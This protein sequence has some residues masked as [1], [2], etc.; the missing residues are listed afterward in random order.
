MHPFTP[1][2]GDR[3]LL[4][5]DGLTNHVS[6]DELRIGP[7][8][9][10]DPQEWIDHLVQ[11]ALDHGS[12]D[13]VT[14]I[15]IAFEEVRH[16]SIPGVR[17]LGLLRREPH[18]N[19]QF[20][21]ESAG[22][23]RSLF[24]TVVVSTPVLLTVVATFILGR[25]SAEMTQAQYQRAV[26]GQKQSKVADEWAFFQA[27]R[28]RGTSY[29]ATAVLLAAQ[30]AD[31][32]TADTLVDA[33]DGLIREIQATEKEV[34]KSPELEALGKKARAQLE[35]ING[36]LHPSPQ[37]PK[38]TEEKI[39]RASMPSTNILRQKSNRSTIAPS[40]PT[41]G[42]GSARSSMTSENSSPNRKSLRRRSTSSRKPSSKPSSWRR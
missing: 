35:K 28:I 31:P 26:A 6:E 3:L 42:P 11:T 2:P 38:L 5:T 21:A 22:E 32:F 25:S 1:L 14:G 15:V 29:E 37:D 18:V 30:K 8:L 27:K 10:P 39:K 4:A 13:N 17:P 33:A 41:S 36:T 23:K 7:R 16:K 20:C 34:G 12:R 9:H 24:E 19:R 40:M